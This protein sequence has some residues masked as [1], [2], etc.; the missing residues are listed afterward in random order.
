MTSTSNAERFSWTRLSVTVIVLKSAADTAPVNS[1]FTDRTV[2][3]RVEALLESF[4]IRG[5]C[6]C[7]FN[8]YIW[9][10]IFSRVEIN[11]KT[12]LRPSAR[13]NFANF[14]R[15]LYTSLRL[16]GLSI[17]AAHTWP[18]PL[19][20]QE[21]FSRYCLNLRNHLNEIIAVHGRNLI[22]FTFCLQKLL[23]KLDKYS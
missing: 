8:A 14:P 21:L 22:C 2:F 12:S 15:P 23:L 16:L 1:L 20:I 6:V 10:Q 5:L 4:D 3:F 13:V 18:L 19:R 11:N 7:V 9:F 17:A